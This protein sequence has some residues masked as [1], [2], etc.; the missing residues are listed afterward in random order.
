LVAA[1]L[2]LLIPIAIFPRGGDDLAAALLFDAFIGGCATL[3]YWL[4]GKRESRSAAAQCMLLGAAWGLAVGY[5]HYWSS[6]DWFVWVDLVVIWLVCLVAQA[7]ICR[8]RVGWR[9]AAYAS[10]LLAVTWVCYAMGT[11][12][13]GFSEDPRM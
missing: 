4:A 7:R 5:A 8:L 12:V 3:C 9:L 13:R 6:C 1:A 2:G 11:L 10:V